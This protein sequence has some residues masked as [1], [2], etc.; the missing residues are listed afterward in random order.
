MTVAGLHGER[1]STRHVAMHRERLFAELRITTPAEDLIVDSFPSRRRVSVS[2]IPH[3]HPGR[4]KGGISCARI[5]SDEAMPG[6]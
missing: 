2:Q 3:R 1:A 5:Y 6:L 4:V